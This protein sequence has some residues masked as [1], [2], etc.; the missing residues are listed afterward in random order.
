MSNVLF[1]GIK[2]DVIEL[3]KINIQVKW[4]NEQ[5][6]IQGENKHSRTFEIALTLRGS[7]AD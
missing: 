7:E 4:L 2:Q 1:L 3:T 6:R 5:G